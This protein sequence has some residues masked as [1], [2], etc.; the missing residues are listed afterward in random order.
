M[1]VLGC[2][3]GALLG[4][5]CHALVAGTRAAAHYQD[6]WRRKLHA[7]GLSSLRRLRGFEMARRFD[8][9]VGAIGVMQAG[10]R[11]FHAV[12]FLIHLRRDP[13][14]VGG[15]AVVMNKSTVPAYTNETVRIGCHRSL[16]RRE[17]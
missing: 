6:P 3:H 11:R 7:T 12:R 1:A 17:H 2:K 14:L 5:E 16:R 10:L 15:L 8:E 9:T 4:E 13:T